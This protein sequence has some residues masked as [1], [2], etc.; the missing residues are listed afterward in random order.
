MRY[1]DFMRQP[2]SDAKA[3]PFLKRLFDPPSAIFRWG[4]TIALFEDM[5]DLKWVRMGGREYPAI[6]LGRISPYHYFSAVISCID[7]CKSVVASSQL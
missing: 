2:C 4:D 5:V 7:R 1:G 6:I 3:F